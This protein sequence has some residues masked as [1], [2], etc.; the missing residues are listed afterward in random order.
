M[1]TVTF[2]TLL[3]AMKLMLVSYGWSCNSGAE[4]LINTCE[5]LDL[6]STIKDQRVAGH[7]KA[8]LL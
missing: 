6:I 3:R 8:Y 5:P 7:I 2:W 4:H 1:Y